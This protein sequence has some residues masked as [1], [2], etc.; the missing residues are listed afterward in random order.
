MVATR[1]IPPPVGTTSTLIPPRWR[2][3]VPSDD[4]RSITTGT[5]NA[6]GRQPEEIHSSPKTEVSAEG[7]PTRGPES[8]S[9]TGLCGSVHDRVDARTH[10]NGGSR[11]PHRNLFLSSPRRYQPRT[12]DRHLSTRW[13]RLRR[14]LCRGTA[15]AGRPAD[16][17][18]RHLWRDRRIRRVQRAVRHHAFEAASHRSRYGQ[19]LR[20]AGDR[21]VRR[22]PVHARRRSRRLR[23]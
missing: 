19:L 23:A 17:S 18:D 3:F 4:W 1:R 9:R 20:I 2:G 16:G 12:T 13:R 10:R 6:I 7:T 5:P 15:I 22:P 21:A 14:I 8:V 11:Q